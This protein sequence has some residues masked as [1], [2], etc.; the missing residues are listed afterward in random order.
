MIN[1]CNTGPLLYNRNIVTIHDIAFQVN[2]K[3]FSPAFVGLY[4]FLIPRIARR[5][6]RVITVS[7][8]SKES[9]IRYTNIPENKVEIVYNGISDVF[10]KA[11]N[12]FIGSEYDN[13]ILAVSSIDPRKNLLSLVRTFKQL[14]KPDLSL[15]IVGAKSKVFADSNLK[16]EIFG[17]PSII[18]TGYISDE[19]LAALY[20][21]AIMFVYPS[22]YE[23]FGIPPL[24]AMAT[25]CPTIT[26]NTTALPEICGDACLYIDPLDSEDLAEKID[27][28]L[29]QDTLRKKLRDNGFRQVKYYSWEKSALKVA[30]I[31]KSH[32]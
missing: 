21:K 5:S 24:E 6:L 11:L 23:G 4:K 7:N 2:P 32:L 25:G 3:W 8:F 30:A 17:W 13:Y 28:L 9:I 15:V 18:F 29:T 14:N 26:S 27:L 20:N 19:K 22:L 12:P 31:I 10:F 1:F 16:D